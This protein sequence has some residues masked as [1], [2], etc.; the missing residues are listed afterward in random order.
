[1]ILRRQTALCHHVLLKLMKKSLLT[2]LGSA[3]FTLLLMLYTQTYLDWITFSWSTLLLITVITFFFLFWAVNMESKRLLL[4]PNSRVTTSFL[5]YRPNG[6]SRESWGALFGRGS[7]CRLPCLFPMSC[8]DLLALWSSNLTQW[9][10]QKVLTLKTAV[11][12]QCVDHE[13]STC[14]NLRIHD[15]G[16][17]GHGAQATT[18]K[19][20]VLIGLEDR[21][22]MFFTVLQSWTTFRWLFSLGLLTRRDRFWTWSHKIERSHKIKLKWQKK[23]SVQKDSCSYLSHD[24]DSFRPKCYIVFGSF[25]NSMRWPPLLLLYWHIFIYHV[26]VM[27]RFWCIQKLQSLNTY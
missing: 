20:Y 16:H 3:G 22:R 11:N 6:A 25:Q 17:I 15:L 21:Y 5:T 13:L 26:Q 14:F 10:T 23:R 2:A 12:D 8:H 19:L 1:M 27:L 4:M 24:K 7:T 9:S 18:F